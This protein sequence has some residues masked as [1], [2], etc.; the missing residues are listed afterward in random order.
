MFTL[1]YLYCAN[2]KKKCKSMFQALSLVNGNSLY[3]GM[4]QINHKLNGL[5]FPGIL[6]WSPAYRGTNLELH[7]TIIKAQETIQE[8]NI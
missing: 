8:M 3:L 6:N 5:P 7:L 1:K 4:F 2:Y